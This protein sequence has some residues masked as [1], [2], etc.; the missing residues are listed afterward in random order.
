MYIIC[1]YTYYYLKFFT[2][3]DVVFVKKKLGGNNRL[4]GN[5]PKWGSKLALDLLFTS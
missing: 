5:I 3:L 2:Q 4:S 1:K